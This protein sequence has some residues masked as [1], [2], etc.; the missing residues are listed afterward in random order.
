MAC[1]F[2]CA[3]GF[4]AQSGRLAPR[5]AWRFLRRQHSSCGASQPKRQVLSRGK[6]AHSWCGQDLVLCHSLAPCDRPWS[7]VPTWSPLITR[8]G[9]FKRVVPAHRRASSGSSPR[10]GT[11]GLRRSF[12]CFLHQCLEPPNESLQRTGTA[13]NSVAV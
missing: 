12:K 2:F 1:M 11:G 5:R 7:S 13:T 3:L 4:S 9:R 8:V 10:L 6:R